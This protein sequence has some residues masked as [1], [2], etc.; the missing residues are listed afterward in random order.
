MRKKQIVFILSMLTIFFVS[1]TFCQQRETKPVELKKISDNLYEILGGS[2]AN[3][4]V[5]IGEN[6][7]LVIDTKMD[8]ES[9]DQTIA[10]IKKI[11][12]KP[13]T[14]VVDTHSDG[15]HING[16]RFFSQ[17]ITFIAHENCRKDF[18][19]PGRNNQPSQWTKPELA[20]FVPSVTFRDKMD[21]YLGSKKVELWYF[22]V[23]HTTGDGV[24]YF[25]EEKAAFVGDQIFTG[26]PQLIHSYKGG[27]SFEHVKTWTK[28]LAT[29]DADRFFSGHS[30]EVDRVFVNDHLKKMKQMQAKVKELIKSGKN[31]EEV[32][33]TFNENEARLI[34]SIFNE[35]K[36]AS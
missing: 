22:G 33:K 7:V 17:K 18:F 11:T 19:L 29:L 8:K 16:N 6:G 34:T 12:R 26:R 25:P 23:G 4:G 1:T 21:I 24:V 15:D 13:I 2:G 5:Y 28:M 32:K 30:E 27:N 10:E 9:V 36:M 14:H 35:L 20:P 31:L 3:G